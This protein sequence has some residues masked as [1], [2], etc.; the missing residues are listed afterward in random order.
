MDLT[1]DNLTLTS[2]HTVLNKT[3]PRALGSREAAAAA[4]RRRGTGRAGVNWVVWARR[5]L[6]TCSHRTP[7]HPVGAGGP[8]HTRAFL[9]LTVLSFKGT[10]RNGAIGGWGKLQTVDSQ[11]LRGWLQGSMAEQRGCPC[12]TQRGRGKSWNPACFGRGLGRGQQQERPEPWSVMHVLNR[13]LV[14]V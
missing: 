8:D 6:T 5:L 3:P 2:H 4:V 14:L 13:S 12:P 1:Q 9:S 11:G 7:P 10:S